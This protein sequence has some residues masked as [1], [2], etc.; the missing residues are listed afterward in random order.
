M[1]RLLSEL[2]ASARARGWPVIVLT[3]DAEPEVASRI[4]S[5]AITELAAFVRMPAKSERPELYYRVDG[6][7]NRDGHVDAAERLRE[8]LDRALQ[9]A[10][11]G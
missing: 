7:W 3:S 8:P 5:V 4:E 10:I 9:A 11:D 1:L 2:I 6:H